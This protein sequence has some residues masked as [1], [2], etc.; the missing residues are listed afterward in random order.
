MDSLIFGGSPEEA[1]KEIMKN[2]PYDLTLPVEELLSSRKRKK[3]QK[4]PR[5]QNKFILFRKDYTARARKQDPDRTK[6]MNTH[7]FSR[8]ASQQWEDHS[9]QVKLFFTILA[10][11]ATE[12]HKA[13]YPGYVYEPEKKKDKP[14]SPISPV[15]LENFMG[16][17]S[18]EFEEY[19]DYSQCSKETDLGIS[20][21]SGKLNDDCQ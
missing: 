17:S 14:A 13:I 3:S 18:D 2:P 7:D 6:L 8:E 10:T 5:A 4:P 15:S 19:I 16:E 20:E 21:I 1:L 11:V 9:P 12:R